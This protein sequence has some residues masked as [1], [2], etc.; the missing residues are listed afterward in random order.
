MVHL[1]RCN[2]QFCIDH[3]MTRFKLA[4]RPTIHAVHILDSF[5]CRPNSHVAAVRSGFEAIAQSLMAFGTEGGWPTCPLRDTLKTFVALGRKSIMDVDVEVLCERRHFRKTRGLSE[6]SLIDEFLHGAL[7]HPGRSAN[8]VQF[9]DFTDASSQEAS[10]RASIAGVS[11]TGANVLIILLD[12][13]AKDS[14]CP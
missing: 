3:H 5:E 9:H 11:G 4:Q 12:R 6:A 13:D 14:I 10:L 8:G 1:L 2:V 7:C